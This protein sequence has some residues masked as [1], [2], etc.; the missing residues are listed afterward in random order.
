MFSY[1]LQTILLNHFETQHLLC[2]GHHNINHTAWIHMV[3]QAAWN[4]VQ[5]T[6]H[7]HVQTGQQRL[8]TPWAAA[9]KCSLDPAGDKGDET[10][11]PG[12]L[13]RCDG[14]DGWT[15]VSF[16]PRWCPHMPQ[17]S[18]HLAEQDDLQEHK[19][20]HSKIP[21]CHVSLP[22]LKAYL[23]FGEEKD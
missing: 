12:S 17:K 4:L 19:D 9:K 8:S 2:P 23:Q 22:D 16:L 18:M 14:Q 20:C 6:Q 10:M 7:T 11:V 5:V 3:P 1:L 21:E 13:H 15:G